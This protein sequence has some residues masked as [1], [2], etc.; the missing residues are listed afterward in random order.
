[1]EH[2]PMVIWRA[3]DEFECLAYGFMA[4][5]IAEAIFHGSDTVSWLVYAFPELARPVG[6][7]ILGYIRDTHGRAVSVFASRILVIGGTFGQ[8][9][10]PTV[11]GLGAAWMM[12]SRLVQGIG[13]GAATGSTM[14]YLVESAPTGVI[15][16][17]GTT[18]QYSVCGGTLLS[19]ALMKPLF[20]TLSD[21]QMQRWGWRDPFVCSALSAGVVIW[22]TAA[23]I[24]ET[25][26]L[27]KM[28]KEKEAER[29]GS[30]PT[31]SSIF[32]GHWRE[33]LLAC[34]GLGCVTA[35]Q[36]LWVTFFRCVTCY[37]RGLKARRSHGSA[38][39]SYHA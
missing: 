21:R 39:I 3:L 32:A 4:P 24:K 35:S 20:A 7:Y 10:T 5:T 16:M 13:Y 23:S 11:P 8:A 9:M 19:I 30:E 36:Y 25:R 2:W 34:S 1:M 22:L 38:V 18:L 14:T 33:L 26:Q 29:A 28:K 37:C 17:S 27:E 15:A 31:I 6:G 12:V